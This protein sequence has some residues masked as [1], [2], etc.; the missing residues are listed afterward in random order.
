M[1]THSI[2]GIMEVSLL[3]GKLMLQSGAETYRVEDTITR[4]A[5]NYGAE[6]AQVFVTPT[7]IILSLRERGEL[8]DY[9]KIA[10]ISNRATDLHVVTLVNDLS[11]KVAQESLPLVDALKELHTIEKEPVA[12]PAW[13]Q[14]IAAVFVSGCF[15]LMFK[16]NY[17]DFIP[18]MVAGGVGYSIFVSVKRYI[19]VRFFSELMAAFFIGLIAKLA[20]DY[21]V[22]N[23]LDKIIIGA[24]MP[25][26]PGVLITNAVRDLMAGHLVSGLSLGAEAMLTAFAIGTGI[27][28]VIVTL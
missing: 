13:M 24:V 21:G 18:S 23:Q 11:R 2:E 7:A 9:T 17:H 1:N 26:V 25:L 16:G 28:F 10:R 14:I 22:G 15:T 27:A 8:R 4:L 19:S 6:T 20:V 12:F 3:A 5:T